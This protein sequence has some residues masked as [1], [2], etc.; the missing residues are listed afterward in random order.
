M[1][2]FPG[3]GHFSFIFPNA[4]LS[5]RVTICFPSHLHSRLGKVPLQIQ[6]PHI[7]C[8]AW[9]AFSSSGSKGSLLHLF[10]CWLR[11]P[12]NSTCATPKSPLPSYVKTSYP[13]PKTF[14][15]QQF[16]TEI[17]DSITANVVSACKFFNFM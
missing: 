8:T 11:P 9:A 6:K 1:P 10:L 15:T 4:R 12:G 13:G 17:K 7:V 16:D 5:S 3:S 2:G 14:G